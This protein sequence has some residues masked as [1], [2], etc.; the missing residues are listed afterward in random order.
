MTIIRKFYRDKG[1][2][3]LFWRINRDRPATNNPKQNNNAIKTKSY[4]YFRPETR[5]GGCEAITIIINVF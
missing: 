3:I 1:S 5:L 2:P 4:E